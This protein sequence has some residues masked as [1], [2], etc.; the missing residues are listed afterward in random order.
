[1]ISM[2]LVYRVPS[3]HINRTFRFFVLRARQQLVPQ[4]PSHLAIFS[5]FLDRQLFS[6]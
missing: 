2:S 6:V 3:L 4:P 5:G 1:M